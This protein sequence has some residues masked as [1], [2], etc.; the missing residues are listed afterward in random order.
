MQGPRLQRVGSMVVR[1]L[2][3][4]I[5]SLASRQVTVGTVD[6]DLPGQLDL[7]QQPILDKLQAIALAGD[8]G[9]ILHH[10]VPLQILERP[11]ST[12]LPQVARAGAGDLGH[13]RQGSCHQA[14]IQDRATA[15]GAIDP[16][17]NQVHWAIVEADLQLDQRIASGE[18]RQRRH[19]DQATNSGR[20]IDPQ[21]TPRITT[22][23]GKHGLGFLQV[24]KQAHATLVIGDAIQGRTD[25]ASGA[26][27]QLHPQVGLQL[28]DQDGHR[29]PGQLQAVGGPGKTTEFDDP[30]EDTHGVK[31]VHHSS[32]NY[33][34]NNNSDSDFCLFIRILSSST[35]A[36]SPTIGVSD[37]AHSTIGP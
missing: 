9:K 22:I 34:E 32:D 23:L 21:R 27:Q 20:H 12:V 26:V 31:T 24:R 25:L 30:G 33:L 6:R 4:S 18:L 10:P 7:P 29:S 14:V 11:R 36:P 37:N 17:A 8:A 19:Q 2:H 3:Q 16:L 35:I 15:Q 5:A 13:L 28:L 1:C